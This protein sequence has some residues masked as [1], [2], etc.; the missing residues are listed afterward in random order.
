MFDVSVQI[1]SEQ[2]RIF[3]TLNIW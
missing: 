3:G 2:P 1:F